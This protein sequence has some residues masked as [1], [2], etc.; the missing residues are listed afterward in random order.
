MRVVFLN[1]IAFTLLLSLLVAAPVL[2]D[3]CWRNTTCSS[4]TEAAFPGPWDEGI[5]APESRLVSPKS[6]L[7]LQDGEIISS[8]NGSASLASNGSQLVFDFGKEVGGIVHLK[9]AASGTGAGAVGLAFTEA[10]N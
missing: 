10:K 6:V 3:S 8:W 9:Y 4:T 1:M 2:G 7:S 5:F